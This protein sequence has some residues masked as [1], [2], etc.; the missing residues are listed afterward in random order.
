[1]DSY[2]AQAL[3]ARLRAQHPDRIDF[4]RAEDAAALRIRT[5]YEQLLAIQERNRAEDDGA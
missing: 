4:E 5:S 3:A 1:M 2:G